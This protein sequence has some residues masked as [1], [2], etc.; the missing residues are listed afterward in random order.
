[1]ADFVEKKYENKKT[2]TLDSLYP[3]TLLNYSGKVYP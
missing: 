2:R 1:M 3:K